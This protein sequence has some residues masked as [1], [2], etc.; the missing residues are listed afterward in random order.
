[1]T[2][3]ELLDLNPLYHYIYAGGIPA[4]SS[5]D[6][7]LAFFREFGEGVVSVR[8][9]KKIQNPSR[10]VRK[11]RLRKVKGYC[12]VEVANESTFQS[13][14]AKGS[15]AFKERNIICFEYKQ[16]IDLEELNQQKNMRRAIIKNVPGDVKPEEIRSLAETFGGPLEVFFQFKSESKSPQ[17]SSQS[18]V[19]DGQRSNA[20]SLMFKHQADAQALYDLKHLNTSS[21]H[22]LTVN[23]FDPLYRGNIQGK[24]PASEAVILSNKSSSSHDSNKGSER[25]GKALVKTSLK[26]AINL[27]RL[28]PDCTNRLYVDTNIG[29]LD[30]CND[31]E[32]FLSKPTTQAYH[33]QRRTLQH[34]AEN[35][36]HVLKIS[37]VFR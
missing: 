33:Q 18:I 29:R 28:Y 25:C 35:L 7:L 3:S 19:S 31:W 13:V 32:A 21:G 27:N 34:V 1:M 15:V 10:P 2:S 23:P 9:F 20:Y 36:Q 37:P 24:K 4:E 6:V 14:I 11:A 8:T 17:L 12:I 22:V 30:G 26:A 16:G 5:A